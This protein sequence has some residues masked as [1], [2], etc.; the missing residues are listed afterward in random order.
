MNRRGFLGSILASGT[1]PAIVR[2][3]SL[4]KVSGIIIPLY[5]VIIPNSRNTFRPI[6]MVVEEL[7]ILYK[8]N[9][10]VFS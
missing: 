10:R 4:M 6:S 2:I 3:E 5:E 8:Q 9:P 1:A 7:A